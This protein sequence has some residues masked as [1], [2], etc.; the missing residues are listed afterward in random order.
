MKLASFKAKGRASYG[1]VTAD[2]GLID[3][4]RKLAKYPTPARPL[5]RRCHRRGA[6]GRDRSA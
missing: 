5:S 2:G 1:A 4:G 6:R 3:L